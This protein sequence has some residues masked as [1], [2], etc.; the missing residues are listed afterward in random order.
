MESLIASV[1][2]SIAVVGIA[3]TLVATSQ[4]AQDVD[5]STIVNSL[6]RELMEEVVAKPF[7][8]P[9]TGDV[10]GW[11]GGNTNRKTYDNLND[12]HAYADI[13]PFQSLGG[14]SIDPGTGQTYTR[15]VQIED[16][17]SPSI[18]W[19]D[20]EPAMLGLGSALDAAGR[21]IADPSGTLRSI[22]FGEIVGP[23]AI[24]T[25]T[26]VPAEYRMVSVKV[27]S[28]SGKSVILNRL[29]CNTTFTK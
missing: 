3:G 26:E 17:L 8:A 24:G 7:K 4:Q 15:E 9:V 27:V 29:M 25:A 21:L 20:D 16:R 6:A 12:F 13:S 18:P 23:A 19:L 11:T 2:L 5:D 14:R 22:C 10:A 28:S 1:V